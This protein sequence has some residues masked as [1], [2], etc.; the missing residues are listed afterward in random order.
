MINDSIPKSEGKF[1]ACL[2][3]LY[4]SGTLVGYADLE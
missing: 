3:L 1:Y 4:S 2:K